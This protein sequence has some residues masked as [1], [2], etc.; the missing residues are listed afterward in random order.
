M[1]CLQKSESGFRGSRHGLHLPEHL[2]AQLFLAV[3]S[4]TAPRLGAWAGHT[5]AQSFLALQ[6]FLAPQSLTAPGE[7]APLQEDAQLLAQSLTAPGATF[8]DLQHFSAEHSLEQF[9]P[10][11]L[12][13]PGLTWL[14]DWLDSQPI[15]AMDSEQA[16]SRER[17][18]RMALGSSNGN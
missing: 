13:T 4:L 18:I 1:I 7:T 11:S 5:A 10:Q 9:A 3:Q 15:M 16:T 12:T 8:A 17:M 14:E 2:L 6:S